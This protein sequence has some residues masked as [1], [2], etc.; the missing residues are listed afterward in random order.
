MYYCEICDE[1]DRHDHKSVKRAVETGK[2]SEKWIKLKEPIYLLV[3]NAKES[4]KNSLP[5]IQFLEIIACK[6]S[7]Y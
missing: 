2:Y 3:K 1:G 5:L 7:N 6:I 4:Y